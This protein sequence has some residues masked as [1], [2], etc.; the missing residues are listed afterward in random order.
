MNNNSI[1]HVWLLAEMY[2]LQVNVALLENKKLRVCRKMRKNGQARQKY[3]LTNKHR[4]NK[5]LTRYDMPQEAT[6]I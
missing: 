2:R 4:N 1:S 3:E 6:Q 5:K